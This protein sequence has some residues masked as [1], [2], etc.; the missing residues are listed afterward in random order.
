MK[1]ATCARSDLLPQTGPSSGQLSPHLELQNR[2]YCMVRSP[3]NMTTIRSSLVTERAK[4]TQSRKTLSQEVVE[5]H[6]LPC[7]S[8][9]GRIS[10]ADPYARCISR[11]QRVDNEWKAAIWSAS[12]M[13]SHSLKE[14]R[15]EG[16]RLSWT[17]NSSCKNAFCG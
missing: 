17:A 12:C 14:R 16:R 4:S 5:V 9:F 11:R 13:S 8:P 7:S 2:N 15:N 1:P 3:C 10:V 6:I